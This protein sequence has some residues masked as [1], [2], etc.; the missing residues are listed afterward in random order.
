MIEYQLKE[1]LYNW[2]PDVRPNVLGK[3]DETDG[4]RQ[5][6][7]MEPLRT[8]ASNWLL[9]P[10]ADLTPAIIA[11]AIAKRLKKLGGRRRHRSRASTPASALIDAKEQSLQARRDDRRR[12][13]PHA[14]VL[15]R[16]PAQHQHARARRL[17]RRGRHRLPL[18][19]RPGSDRNTATFT[20]MGGEGV[21]WVGPGAVH[22]REAHLRQPR[23]RHLL[24]QRPA[25][26]PPGH[27]G[28]R[29]HHLQDPL[30]RRGRHDRRP[31]GRRAARRP[32]GAADHEQPASAEGVAKLVIVT[33]EP[34]KY[35]GAPLAP[36]VDGAPPRRAGRAAARVP[37]D[38]PARTVIIYDQTCAT[39]KRR[40]RKRGTLVDPAKR[41]VINE[42]VCE[43]CGD[44]S[45]QSQLPVGRAAGD[46]VRP[47]APHQPEHLQQGLTPA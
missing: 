16:L 42:L 25:G 33:D 11:R 35:D 2:R 23:R 14:V 5:R 32:L 18:H 40:R 13:R 37:R 6:R 20:Q 3:F 26:D 30:Q 46:R 45:V 17:A 47:Q 29:E 28:G 12:R 10:Q 43:G 21:T 39:E 27:R 38:S 1:E 36:G 19:G 34:Q 31:A 22:R 8:R 4:D 9:R 7:R 24:P 41:V 15:Q 44:C